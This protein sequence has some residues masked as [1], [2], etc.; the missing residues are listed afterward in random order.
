MKASWEG[1]A[2]DDTGTMSA[3]EI[4][5]KAELVVEKPGGYLIV[6]FH[7]IGDCSPC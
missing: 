1:D 5:A 7:A 6:K 3:L 2:D 4:W